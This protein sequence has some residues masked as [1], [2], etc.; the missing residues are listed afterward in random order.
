MYAQ[1]DA[2]ILYL[3]CVFLFELGSAVCG[4]APNIDALIIGRAICG[5]GGAGMYTGVMTLL[6]VTT[7]EHER[8]TYIGLTGLTWGG[9]TVL[10]KSTVPCMV[11]DEL[12]DKHQVRSLAAPFLIVVR[13]GDGHSVSSVFLVDQPW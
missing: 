13:P 4:A 6:S 8:P 2:K 7:T 10:G 5:W 1:F 9:G 3:I 11:S 12:A